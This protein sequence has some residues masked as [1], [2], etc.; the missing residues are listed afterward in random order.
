M[1]VEGSELWLFLAKLSKPNIT[2]Q[3]IKI[4][5]FEAEN[6]FESIV[7]DDNDVRV[8]IDIFNKGSE[9][10]DKFFIK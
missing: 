8:L 2:L 9:L 3:E 6:L 4:I 7:P 1:S 5:Y 10:I